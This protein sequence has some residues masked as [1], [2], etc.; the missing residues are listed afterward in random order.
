M[1]LLQVSITDFEWLS[2]AAVA[3]CGTWG[4]DDL[5]DQIAYELRHALLV[6]LLEW[7]S[8]RQLQPS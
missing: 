8:L 7:K 1:G 3:A 5:R 4:H 6:W 2:K